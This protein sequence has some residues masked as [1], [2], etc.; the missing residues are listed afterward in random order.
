MLTINSIFDA[1]A[2]R[3]SDRYREVREEGRAEVSWDMSLLTIRWSWRD[4]LR[5]GIRLDALWQTVGPGCPGLYTTSRVSTRGRTVRVNRE[6]TLYRAYRATNPRGAGDS[7]LLLAD[8]EAP[9]LVADRQVADE[10]AYNVVVAGAR[11]RDLISRLEAARLWV[12]VPSV[13]EDFDRLTA[14]AT[15]L[16]ERIQREYDFDVATSPA[17]PRVPGKRSARQWAMKHLKHRNVPTVKALVEQWDTASGQWK[18]L[19][20]IKD[21]LVP[22]DRE[23]VEIKSSFYKIVNRRYQA[24]HFWPAEVVGKDIVER[25]LDA[26]TPQIDMIAS[27]RGRWFRAKSKF[28]MAEAGKE[29]KT[30]ER[31]ASDGWVDDWAGELRQLQAVD[32]SSSQLQILA[33]FCG[34]TDLENSLKERPF[35]EVIAAE[36]WRRSEDHT[37]KF[38]LPDGFGRPRDEKLNNAIK[39][40]VMTSIYGSRP[41]D[42]A[43]M[44]R[45]SWADYGPGLGDAE[46][47]KRLLRMAN[48][49]EL[50]GVY[51]PLCRAIAIKEIQAIHRESRGTYGAPR[52]HAELV[53][54]GSSSIP[55]HSRCPHVGPARLRCRVDVMHLRSQDPSAGAGRGYRVQSQPP[56]PWFAR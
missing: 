33:V 26:D 23:D 9:A 14:M 47:I 4:L 50:M 18:Q 43:H 38:T 44:L 53:A 40:A 25:Q 2:A 28:E 32:V 6:A 10:R 46:N 31:W 35:K 56:Q 12:R 24:A 45:E 29:Q 13:V 27:R 39:M 49:A 16:R 8:A 37:D 48:V 21:Q 51:L 36:A 17:K 54:R 5:N 19:E 11:S 22:L 3:W 15:A 7:R 42:V 55:F 52:V 1:L 34:L 20:G 41:P 30:A